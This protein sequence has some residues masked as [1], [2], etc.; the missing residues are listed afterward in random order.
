L[1]FFKEIQKI[2]DKE[3]WKK[4]FKRNNCLIYLNK[5][6]KNNFFI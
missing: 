1:F 4:Q 5:I 3:I 2:L 6:K